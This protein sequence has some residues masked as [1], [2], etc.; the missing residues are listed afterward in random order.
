M[1]TMLQVHKATRYL[2]V[3]TVVVYLVIYSRRLRWVG[4][5]NWYKLEGSLYGYLDWGNYW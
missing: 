4:N 5:S 2:V 3:V 1:V